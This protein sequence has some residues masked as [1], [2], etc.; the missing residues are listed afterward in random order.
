MNFGVRLYCLE[1]WYTGQ[2]SKTIVRMGKVYVPRFKLYPLVGQLTCNLKRG[3]CE[4]RHV[5]TQYPPTG[6]GADT[7]VIELVISTE[8]G[9]S[10]PPCPLFHSYHS[11]YCA[12]ASAINC[13]RKFLIY[14]KNRT[15]FICYAF[16]RS[17]NR[18]P[19][20]QPQYLVPVLFS[21]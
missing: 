9:V 4:V 17:V 8:A 1:I 11:E 13:C 3:A 5:H 18:L 10:G 6:G 2:K 19:V 7:V 20:T 12:T 16:D 14:L 21:Y 15:S